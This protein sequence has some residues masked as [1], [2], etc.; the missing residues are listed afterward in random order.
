MILQNGS[1]GLLWI[2]PHVGKHLANQ[3]VSQKWTFSN[4][5]GSTKNRHAERKIRDSES[6]IM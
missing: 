3:N 2:N 6:K 1:F 5:N 4:S